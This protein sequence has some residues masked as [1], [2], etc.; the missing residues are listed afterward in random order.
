MNIINSI[1]AYLLKREHRQRESHYPSDISDCMRKLYYKWTNEPE[2]NP[3]T[4]SGL[5]KMEMGKAI[6][7]QFN[8]WLEDAGFDVIDE[9]GGKKQ[10]DGLRYPISYR[11]DNVIMEDG[12]EVGIEIKTKYG[13][14]I[15][16]IEKNR[17]P[18]ENDINQVCFYIYLSGINK[19]Y[20]IYVGRDNAYRTQFEISR[21]DW[22]YNIDNNK[23]NFAPNDLIE[24]LTWLEHYVEVKQLPGRD[25]NVIIKNGE[26]KKQ[27][28]KDKI[29]YKSDWQC[30]YCQWLDICWQDKLNNGEAI[31]YPPQKEG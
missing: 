11:V 3:I 28:Q 15:V 29:V 5:W 9:I 14:G 4:A 20:L 16:D 2:S 22:E 23:I 10:I 6:H 7:K 30:N 1:D 18:Q 24:K 12:K 19:W 26:I 8:K 13:R 31:L 27:I 25:F 17:Q 21:Y